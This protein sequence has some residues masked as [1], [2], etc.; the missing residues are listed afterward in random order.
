MGLLLHFLQRTLYLDAG[1]DGRTGLV[2]VLHLCLRHSLSRD[3]SNP[4]SLCRAAGVAA[5]PFLEE[6]WPIS[7]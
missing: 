2:R 1:A 7:H 5:A 4:F 6:E 3:T